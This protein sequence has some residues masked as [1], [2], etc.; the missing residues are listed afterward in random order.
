MI[1]IFLLNLLDIYINTRI[2]DFKCSCDTEGWPVRSTHI[3]IRT[4]IC[5]Y[6]YLKRDTS[7]RTY[8]AKESKLHLGNCYCIYG[9]KW[10]HNKKA[11]LIDNNQ[12][13]ALSLL[14]FKKYKTNHITR[15]KYMLN[16]SITNPIFTK[17]SQTWV[18]HNCTLLECGLSFIKLISVIFFK[19]WKYFNCCNRFFFYII[20][21]WFLSH[22]QKR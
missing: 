1:I 9:V 14:V 12:H 15:G 21:K 8:G 18:F 19:V 5:Q 10:I 11:I 2:D 6:K 4:N 22:L 16:L 13:G 3:Q 17:F 7:P 20:C